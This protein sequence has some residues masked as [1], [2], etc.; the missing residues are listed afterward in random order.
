MHITKAQIFLRVE[1]SSYRIFFY[2]AKLEKMQLSFRT[3]KPER[4]LNNRKS[5]IYR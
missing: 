5:I 3:I 2:F 4:Q 1:I